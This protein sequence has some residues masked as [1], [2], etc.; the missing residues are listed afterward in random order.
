MHCLARAIF[1][2]DANKLYVVKVKGG[3]DIDADDDANVDDVPTENHRVIRLIM[4]GY[5]ISNLGFKVNVL[6]EIIYQLA[7]GSMNE[8]NQTAFVEKSDEIAKCLLKTDMNIDGTVDTIDTVLWM[9]FYGKDE[10]L[11]H[12]YSLYYEPIIDK[13]HKNQNIYNEALSIY[14]NPIFLD[15]TVY[16]LSNVTASSAIGRGAVCVRKWI[17]DIRGVGRECSIF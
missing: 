6:T 8:T 2:R 15:T 4:S 5:E 14:K 3:L 12:N 13:I 17:Y 9:L 10:L 1:L 11:N 7:K 16:F